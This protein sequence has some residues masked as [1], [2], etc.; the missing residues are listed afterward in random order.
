MK[1]TC[2]TDDD[3]GEKPLSHKSTPSTKPNPTYI[4]VSHHDHAPPVCDACGEVIEHSQTFSMIRD[5][6]NTTG[7]SFKKYHRGCN[8]L[9]KLG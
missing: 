9:F 1:R 3:W 2:S 6:C 4:D 7:V 5:K 8:P